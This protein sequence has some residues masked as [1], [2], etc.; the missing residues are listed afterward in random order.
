[1]DPQAVLLLGTALLL[2]AMAARPSKTGRFGYALG[3]AGLYTLVLAVIFMAI[4]GG[5]TGV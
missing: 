3:F 1:M 2:G 4:F 5:L